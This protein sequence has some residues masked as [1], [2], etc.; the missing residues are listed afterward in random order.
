MKLL[1][2]WYKANLPAVPTLEEQTS[3]KNRFLKMTVLVTHKLEQ[4]LEATQWSGMGRRIAKDSISRANIFREYSDYTLRGL[5]LWAL[6]WRFKKIEEKRQLAEQKENE[7]AKT[8]KEVDMI[9]KW[10]RETL[11][12]RL[13]WVSYV[14]LTG[15]A[16]QYE[17]AKRRFREDSSDPVRQSRLSKKKEMHE[18]V[19]KTLES[20][21]EWQR[22]TFDKRWQWLNDMRRMGTADEYEEARAKFVEEST[23][24]GPRLSEEFEMVG[25]DVEEES[26]KWVNVA[27][28][29]T[30]AGSAEDLCRVGLHR[31]NC[32]VIIR[33]ANDRS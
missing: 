27:E 19:A 2:A 5:V 22:E 20:I 17:E 11:V 26:E 23:D 10:Q 18:K 33:R 24:P 29:E 8:E 13:E 25:K 16:E 4:K 12:E 1:L 3:V 31:C 14:R 9:R 15:T 28:D 6:Q 30:W 7:A 32:A 21:R